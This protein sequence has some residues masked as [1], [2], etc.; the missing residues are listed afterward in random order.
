MYLLCLFVIVMILLFIF[1]NDWIVTREGITVN[2]ASSGYYYYNGH[3]NTVRRGQQYYYNDDG[4]GNISRSRQHYYNDHGNIS[5]S[6]QHYYTDH[7]NVRSK[8]HYYTDNG[9]YPGGA[10]A[11]SPLWIT[12]NYSVFYDDPYYGHVNIIY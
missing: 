5:R 10:M 1:I 9:Y 2:G 12:P 4:N 3:R 8:Q 6:R 11:I 7:G